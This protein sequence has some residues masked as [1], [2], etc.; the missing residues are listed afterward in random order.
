MRVIV[1]RE[2]C[3]GAGLC[4]LTAPDLFDQSD[5]DGRVLPRVAASELTSAERAR[6]AADLCPSG[7]LTV[8]EETA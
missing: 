4:V 6:A 5:D 8:V 1:D 7:A 3:I 2:L